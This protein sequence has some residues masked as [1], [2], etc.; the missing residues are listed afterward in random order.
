MA[1]P[2]SERPDADAN[3]IKDVASFSSQI[4]ASLKANLLPDMQTVSDLAN[5]FR[6]NLVDASS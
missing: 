2:L 3:V 6:D 5:D 4:Q 1:D